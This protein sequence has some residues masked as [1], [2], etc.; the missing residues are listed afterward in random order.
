MDLNQQPQRDISEETN[1]PLSS[2]STPLDTEQ[3]LLVLC[4]RLVNI[5]ERVSSL[6]NPQL[7]YKRPTSSDRERL[8]DTL[9]YLHNNIEG[10]KEDLVK[11]AQRI[12]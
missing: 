4:Q 9:D 8:A 10:I 12:R 2:P 11:F 7:M 6:E 1:N 5:E 3:I